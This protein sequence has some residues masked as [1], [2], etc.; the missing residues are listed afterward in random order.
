MSHWEKEFSVIRMIVMVIYSSVF[1]YAIL[2]YLR[3]PFIPYIWETTQQMVFF[4]LLV[5]VIP[6]FV[7]SALIG[8]QIMSP[9]KLSEKFHDAGGGETGL[10]AAV[11]LTRSGGII[12]AAMGEACAIYGLVLYFLSGDTTRPII[13]F[14]LSILHYPVTM[15]RVNKARAEVQ[16]LLR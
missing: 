1:V 5:A 10:E 15:A 12:M 2:V 16:K 9:E 4:A 7:A 14:V 3:I 8:K 6:I 13:F 11:G